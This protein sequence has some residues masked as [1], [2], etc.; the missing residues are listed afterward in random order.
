MTPWTVALQTRIHRDSP[1]KN[2][3]VGCHALLQGIFPTQGLNL[4]LPHY[5]QILY[6][7]SHR[8][9]FV[10]GKEGKVKTEACSPLCWACRAS[11]L[12]HNLALTPSPKSVETGSQVGPGTEAP[13]PH[14]RCSPNAPG[15]ALWSRLLPRAEELGEDSR[16]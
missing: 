9:D 13:R 12:S 2:T 8:E 4:G 15:L 7:L 3:G 1:G 11:E 5:R 6:H 14:G 16:P 10:G